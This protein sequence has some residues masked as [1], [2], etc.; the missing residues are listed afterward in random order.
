MS[1]VQ[2]WYIA[3]SRDYPAERVELSGQAETR[4]VSEEDIFVLASDHDAEVVRLREALRDITVTA[5]RFEDATTELISDSD[6][7][8]DGG[9]AESQAH[10]TVTSIPRAKAILAESQEDKHE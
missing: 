8:R 6:Y 2:R 4:D 7:D 1:E 3:Q 5:E 9:L 10:L